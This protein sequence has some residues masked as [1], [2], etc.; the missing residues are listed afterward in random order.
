MKSLSRVQ[1]FNNQQDYPNNLLPQCIMYV[2]S[3]CPWLLTN[4]IVTNYKNITIYLDLWLYRVS[5]RWSILQ[6]KL[7]KMTFFSC[8]HNVYISYGW[9]KSITHIIITVLIISEIRAHI[10]IWVKFSKYLYSRMWH[11]VFATI[12]SIIWNPGVRRASCN[13]RQIFY[14]QKIYQ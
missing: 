2:P 11:D 5:V 1:L 10:C 9:V 14:F 7:P 6:L 13:T 4:C 8:E 3:K 12:N